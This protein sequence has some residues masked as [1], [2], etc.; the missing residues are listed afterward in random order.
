LTAEPLL[1]LLGRLAT[2]LAREGSGMLCDELM[3]EEAIALVR[4][5]LTAA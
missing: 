1:I 5:D 2:E 4:H 3:A